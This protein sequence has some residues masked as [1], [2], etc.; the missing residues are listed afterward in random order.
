[1]VDLRGR[2]H[3]KPPFQKLEDG[4]LF[5]SKKQTYGL[6]CL[7]RLSGKPK[8]CMEVQI[9][10]ALSEYLTFMSKQSLNMSFLRVQTL[11]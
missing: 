8:L 7:D 9:F 4:S 2:S 5:I 10:V 3:I 11:T 1:M 6:G